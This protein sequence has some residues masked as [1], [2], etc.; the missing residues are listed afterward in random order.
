M[1]IYNVTIMIISVLCMHFGQENF[2][3][4]HTYV[5]LR[6]QFTIRA[7]SEKYESERLLFILIFHYSP[8]K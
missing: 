1:N 6:T 3:S 4:L 7:Y 8:N 2:L 5:D